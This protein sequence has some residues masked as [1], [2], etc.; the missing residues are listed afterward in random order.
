VWQ[1]GG[2]YQGGIILSPPIPVPFDASLITSVSSNTDA[3]DYTFSA[4]SIGVAHDT[5]KVVCAI[6]WGAAS[7]PPTLTGATIGGV[8]AAVED[9]IT[10]AGSTFR[11]VAI[12]SAD[13][14]TGTTGDIVL[15]FSGTITRVRVDV[16]RIINH[17]SASVVAK[18]NTISGL[19]LD[20]SLTVPATVGCIIGATANGTSGDDVDWVG[21]TEHYD[22]TLEVATV[23]VSGAFSTSVAAGPVTVQVTNIASADAVAI[24]YSISGDS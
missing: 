23:R 9:Q 5:R 22:T 3:A 12:I 19:A 15:N 21:A 4:T 10:K 18:D 24:A 13:V 6:L 1:I 8:T 14:P 16:Y 7:G 11:G 17:T 2:Y 20:V